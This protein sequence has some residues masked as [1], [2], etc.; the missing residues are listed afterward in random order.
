MAPFAQFLGT[1]HRREHFITVLIFDWTNSSSVGV[2]PP[3]SKTGFHRVSKYI[4]ILKSKA[5]FVIG[6]EN[7]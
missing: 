6:H 5:I 1:K 4:R 7:L 3:Q 2:L